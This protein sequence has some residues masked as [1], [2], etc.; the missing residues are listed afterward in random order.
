M[1]ESIC[2]SITVG[3]AFVVAEVM[4]LED[5]HLGFKSPGLRGNFFFEFGSLELE[6][7]RGGNSDRETVEEFFGRWDCLLFHSLLNLKLLLE[8]AFQHQFPRN[9]CSRA[10]L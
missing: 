5:E 6:D 8:K 7:G 2:C 10:V 4:G 9:L 3:V 1:G